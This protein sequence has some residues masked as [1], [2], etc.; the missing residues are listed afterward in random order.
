MAN[1]HFFDRLSH[2]LR[3]RVPERLV[4]AQ[5]A[6]Y[7]G[8]LEITNPDVADYYCGAEIFKATENVP[9]FCRLSTTAGGRGSFD[10]K[11]DL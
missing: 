5:G 9:L 8:Y 6:G 4:H 7:H 1:F 10:L 11:R 3:E 2:I